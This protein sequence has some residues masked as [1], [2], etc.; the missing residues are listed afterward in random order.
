MFTP[1]DSKESII[2]TCAEN[3]MSVW[4]IERILNAGTK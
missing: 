3:G 2:K 1:N 4:E